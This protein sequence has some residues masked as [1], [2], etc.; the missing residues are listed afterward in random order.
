MDMQ[1]SFTKDFED[2]YEQVQNGFNAEN[3]RPNLDQGFLSHRRLDRDDSRSNPRPL[4][5]PFGMAASQ[6]R[7]L[8]RPP[9]HL[10]TDSEHPQYHASSSSR[11]TTSPTRGMGGQEPISPSQGIKRLPAVPG[12]SSS[13]Y[14][15]PTSQIAS[16]YFDDTPRPEAYEKGRGAALYA[17]ALPGARNAQ[18]SSYSGVPV[19]DVAHAEN[20]YGA[21][22]NGSSATGVDRNR[23][24]Y[25]GTTP[26]IPPGGTQY[27]SDTKL[28]TD[29]GGGQPRP[30]P[31]RTPSHTARSMSTNTFDS[32]NSGTGSNRFYD[33][34][35]ATSPLNRHL[36]P[37]TAHG[38]YQSMDDFDTSGIGATLLRNSSATSS[39]SESSRRPLLSGTTDST[40]VSTSGASM[41]ESLSS[42][43][44]FTQSPVPQIKAPSHVPSGIGYDLI[45][46]S[47][48][49]VKVSLDSQA[50]DTKTAR[51]WD[52]SGEAHGFGDDRGLDHLL[53]IKRR[54]GKLEV[55]DP[56]QDAFDGV[57]DDDYFDEEDEDDSRFINL[58]L[59]S[60]I[61][62]RLRDKVPRAT[63]VK[64]SIP[65]PRAF[66][67]KDIVSTIQSIIQREILIT[68]GISTN[69]RR[70]ALQ[71]ARSLQNQLFFYEVEWGG[72]T[73]SD[74]V[75]DVYMFLD[76]EMPGEGEAGPSN[77]LSEGFTELPTGVIT[78]APS[79]VLEST[80]SGPDQSASKRGWKQTVTQEVIDSIGE[81]EVRRQNIIHKMIEKEEQFVQDLEFIDTYFI[82][83]LRR[84]D[85]PIVP[86]QDLDSLIDDIFG[87]I[88]D[89]RETNKRLLEN[90]YV[91]Q[92]EQKP[93][94]QKIGDIFLTA[95]AE[96]RW[97]YPVYIGHLPVAEKRLKDELESNS[98]FRLFLES[99]ARLPESRR[100]DLKHFIGRPSDHLR[101]YPVLLEATLKET[102]PENPDVD[103]LSAA[104]QAIRNLSSVAQLRTFQ[105][106]M[107]RNPNGP[108]DWHQLVSKEVLEA[109]PKQEQQ[110]QSVIFELIYGEMEFVRD[111]ETIET[112]FIR[113]LRA[114]APAVIPRDRLSAFIRDVFWTYSDVLVHHRKLLDRLHEIQREEHPHI[115]SIT[116]PIYDAALNWQDAYMEYVPHY[117]ISAFR[118][119]EELGNNPAFKAFHDT[120]LRNPDSRKLDLKAFV[121]R[122]IPRLLRYDLL[123]SQIKKMLP[124]GHEDI[125]A[126]PQVCDIIKD[127]GKATESGV[128]TAEKKVELWNFHANL[129][130]KPGEAVDMDLL[131]ETRQLVHTGK[132]LRPPDGNFELS[133]W[134][135]LFVILFDNYLVMTKT[136]ERDGIT[137]YYANKRPIPLELLSLVGF[138][139]L[140]QQRSAG[141]F[142]RGLKGTKEGKEVKDPAAADPNGAGAEDS[143]T[144]WPCSIHH[145]GRVGGLYHLFADSAAVRG[146]WK[147]KLEEAIALRNLVNDSNKVFEMRNLSENTFVVPSIM[148]G[149]SPGWSNDVT[150][151]GKVTCSVPF[152]TADGR[153]LV[154]VGCA[155]GVWIG[156]RSDKNYRIALR[157]VLHL[158]MVTQCAML[159]DFGIFLVLAD[160]SLFAYHIEAL[161]PSPNSPHAGGSRTPQKLNGTKDVQFF[162]VGTLNGR[163]L[164]IYMKK[165]GM[166]SV[167]RVLEPVIGKITEKAKAP[168][169]FGRNLFGGS[170]SE[171]FRVYRDFF[172]PSESYDL[173]FLK[174]KIAIPCT[175]GFEIMDL[176]DFKSVTIPQRDDPRL[177]S[178]ARRLENCKAMGMFRTSENEFL[179]C[180]DEFG[181]FVDR[182]G[183]PNRVN[184]LVEWEGTAERV[185]YHPPYVVIFDSR[186]VEIRHVDKGRLVQIIRGADIRCLWDG[187]GASLPAPVTPG[188]G[189]WDEMGSL[190]ARIHAVMRAPDAQPNSKVVVQH[191]FELVP[192]V[193]LYTPPPLS[194]PAGA[195]QPA[196]YYQQQ[197]STQYTPQPQGQPQQHQY[198]QYAQQPQY[199][200]YQ[201]YPQYHAGSPPHSPNANA[202]NNVMQTWR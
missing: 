111:L 14:V 47:G 30:L 170:R 137:K 107:A 164:I 82:K 75:E 178:V 109:T 33:S 87:N 77:G 61:A 66:T 174:A 9:P 180:Y 155:E 188:P 5:N 200:Q 94:I 92:R 27:P 34:P 97:A 91:R 157:R 53:D 20:G 128:A 72:R 68:L 95:A 3:P 148:G 158:K 173:L 79:V 59:L 190:E 193:P 24:P 51:P 167:F 78:V 125:E 140:Q 90:M 7:P 39:I 126:I 81:R 35:S 183:D 48:S 191:V 40:R 46:P 179:L 60:H 198:P 161:V 56:D 169:T 114:A 45:P 116:A 118:I 122:P 115:R 184:G 13:S 201:Q 163:T 172:L 36:S 142:G 64:G 74:S 80:P 98:E 160:K 175:K 15:S 168:A 28:R 166:D 202:N 119:Q 96:F 147:Q 130:F 16:S 99:V 71:V 112:L 101:N 124:A 63:H 144:V 110:R 196:N 88:L 12:A 133:G 135:E 127:L 150:F 89:L 194:A 73:L 149:T 1:R 139:E 100:L 65:Y 84:A 134:T 151:T 152:S 83:A 103:F 199:S 117:P 17:S 177:A 23:S 181:L 25:M 141:I 55:H 145:A 154:A 162:S 37:T 136:K 159:E 131:D 153:G 57:G 165:K 120:C 52:E 185:A 85:P 50:Y 42:Y 171:W 187:R 4:P 67:G 123:L 192:T 105:N 32:V 49:D 108:K 121:F 54:L 43:N 8:P 29:T 143:R 104:A 132:L 182:H 102:D 93:V 22:P 197:Q 129:V 19:I 41:T 6:P 186:F 18:Q 76:D 189:G 70:I 138:T 21:A 195:G 2:L 176:T 106:G 26:L 156:L 58:A 113:P 62:V 146:E 31:T 38:D 86:L 69:D 44:R 11:G 10:G